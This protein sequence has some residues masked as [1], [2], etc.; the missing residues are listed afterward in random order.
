MKKQ[1]RRVDRINIIKEEHTTIKSN[2]ITKSYPRRQYFIEV[3][4]EGVVLE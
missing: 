3:S 2:N 1:Y 4:L